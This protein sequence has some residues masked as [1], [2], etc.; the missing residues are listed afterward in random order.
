ML[1]HSAV[2]FPLSPG[3]RAADAET[4]ADAPPAHANGAVRICSGGT[5]GVACLTPAADCP[6]AGPL[7]ASLV[8][9]AP[10]LW[11]WLWLGVMS[12]PLLLAWAVG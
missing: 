4:D 6:D 10:A 2:A 12:E 5:F 9:F 8:S 7:C 1:A 3:A 11:L